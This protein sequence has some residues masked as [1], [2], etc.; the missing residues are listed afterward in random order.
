MINCIS[1]S[2]NELCHLGSIQFKPE[3]F[4]EIE[5][6]FAEF[7]EEQFLLHSRRKR[8][9]RVNEVLCKLI[10]EA[11]P[12]SFLLSSVL[13]FIDR[14]NRDNIT[15]ESYNLTLFEFWLNN[16]SGLNDTE[17]NEIRAKIA[18]KSV[19]RSEYQ[20]VF[21]I[22]MDKIYNGSHFVIA[23]LSPDIDTM[24]ASFWG[25]LD[26]FAARIGTSLHQWV[27]PDG[28]PDSPFTSIFQGMLGRN[29]FRHIPRATSS[30]N[31]TSLDL[32][33]QKNLMK[34]GGETFTGDLI[35]QEYSGKAIILIDE[36][37]HYLGDWRPSDI[38]LTRQ[39]TIPF[40]SYLRWFENNLHSNLIS[41]FAK[42][43]LTVKEFP[44]FYSSIFNI[45]IKECGTATEFNQK[46]IE[47]L[48]IFFQ[49]IFGLDQGLEATFQDLNLVLKERLNGKMTDFQ[50]ELEKLCSSYIFD[51]QG[52]LKENRP[53]I[54][55]QLKKIIALLDEAMQELRN[56]VERLD[57]Q[58]RI[59]HEVL[60]IA[61]TY[62]TMQSDVEEMRFKMESHDFLTVVI[63][64]MGG[65]LF[66]VGII[67]SA[68][69]ARNSLATV[70]F[71]DFCNL[72]E[73]KMSSYF[74]VISVMDHHKNSL[75]TTTVP[76]ALIAD[77]QSCNILLAEQAFLLNDKYSLGGLT[78]T[79]IRDQLKDLPSFFN[80]SSGEMRIH[81]RLMQRG[82]AAIGQSP[83][84]IHPAREYCE[85]LCF[86][87]A[88]LDDTDLLTKVSTR[89]LKCIAELLNRLKSLSLGKEVE[90]IS[91]DDIPLDKNFIRL[92]SQRILQ[93][94]DMYSLYK[95]IY[96]LKEQS[97]KANLEL[98]IKGENSNL[99]IDTKEQNGCARVGQT[100]LFK[101]NFPYF[102][103]HAMDMRKTW[104]DKSQS[105]HHEHPEIDLHIHMIST[106]ASAEE[107]FKGQIGPYEHQDELWF[108]IPNTQSAYIHLNSFLVNFNA[109][110]KNALD[111]LHLE[112]IGK[113]SS[114]FTQIFNQSF[115][116]IKTVFTIDE[117]SDY[118]MAVLRFSAGKLNS[119]KS[120]ISP[121]LPRLIT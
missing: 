73:V 11:P 8:F 67:R 26:A 1:S 12:K 64:E 69:V 28:P 36:Q 37:G 24:I 116:Q 51:D 82:L 102:L 118:R 107:V 47:L 33:H 21:P 94:P 68:D 105:V 106:I 108:W 50:N 89:D 91:F 52:H 104:L 77:V 38:E 111:Q 97:I 10:I 81:R 119:R 70:T 6:V 96:Q 74:E 53:E 59:K 17:N 22:G 120:M 85:Y 57:I 76:S 62:L 117:L 110:V 79:Q 65:Q 3:T 101:Q 109:G 30:L 23:H 92:A 39:I 121:F 14:V 35:N 87:Q 84:Y 63:P 29:L 114:E 100:K 49:K 99:F 7:K 72:E 86:L 5:A 43:K 55:N 113:K 27:L 41:W 103:E 40:K 34:V 66:P 25:W 42:E 98:C 75:K 115:P 83:Y 15:Q 90:I 93:Q 71:R 112:F 18:G 9:R 31:L 61:Q 46:Q 60:N 19:P 45:K 44:A 58:L 16:F 78:E 56:Y 48:H 54:F 95:H 80:S 13:D 88:I 20:G 32:V 2:Q 4:P